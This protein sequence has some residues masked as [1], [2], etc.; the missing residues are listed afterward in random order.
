MT[1]RAPTSPLAFTA[2]AAVLALNAT[3]VLAQD[4]AAADPVAVTAAPEPAP[5][6]PVV[7]APVASPAPVMTSSPIVQAAPVAAP[8][9]T[10]ETVPSPEQAVAPVA[11]RAATPARNAPAARTSAAQ[12][13]T[14][15]ATPVAMSGE[16]VAVTPVE[17]IGAGIAATA[18]Q[19]AQAMPPVQQAAVAPAEAPSDPTPMLLGLL[20]LAAL[21]GAGAY[22][23]NRRRRSR[24]EPLPAST[25]EPPMR[26]AEPKPSFATTPLAATAAASAAAPQPD[27]PAFMPREAAWSTGAA[28]PSVTYAATTDRTETAVIEREVRGDRQQA[29]A[30]IPA[31][32]LPTGTAMAALM[33][34]MTHAAP[35]ADNPFHSM[36]RRRK[37]VRWL[38]K[39]H[40]Y[41]L[42][43]NSTRPFD[44]REYKPSSALAREEGIGAEAVPA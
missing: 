11:T 31:G 9:A 40:E 33:D 22:A 34:R 21:G 28:A 10:A 14:P 43:R 20:G 19:S 25:Y 13:V 16:P 12:A 35:D 29:S 5:A 42:R 39:Q 4:A 27:K 41:A 8:E 15:A 38:L 23:V 3:P 18:Q 7:E 37:R 24:I 1:K 32:P 26:A 6:A 36:K 30:Q 2:I 17:Q 44:Y